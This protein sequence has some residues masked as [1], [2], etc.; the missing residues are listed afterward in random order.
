MSASDR[1]Y[2]AHADVR[3]GRHA[4]ERAKIAKA[5]RDKG[6]FVAWLQPVQQSPGWFRAS[7]T[8]RSLLMD[9]LHSGPNGKLSASMKY[10]SKSGWTSAGTVSRAVK[11]LIEC[12]LLVETRMG[13]RPN[14]P[15]WYAVTWLELQHTEGLDIDPRTFK[16]GGY[17]T[18][19]APAHAPQKRRTAAATAARQMNAIIRADGYTPI[20]SD[21]QIGAP[22]CTVTR[23]I[24]ES[25][26]PSNGAME[27]VS[28]PSIRPSDGAYL[29]IAIY[30]VD[31]PPA[32]TRFGD[33]LLHVRPTNRPA[34]YK[35]ARAKFHHHQ[36]KETT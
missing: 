30:G 3:A 11:K 24:E 36:I 4:A 9:M 23:S 22:Y 12:G 13:A 28:P 34:S 6:Y 18:P 14:K 19:D 10:L 31:K 32:R 7:H 5:G 27:P 29:D 2:Q 15:A 26:S 1:S 16:R 25:I 20:P 8:A 33:A 21:G 17:M 35:A